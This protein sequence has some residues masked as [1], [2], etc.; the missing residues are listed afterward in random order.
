VISSVF[1]FLWPPLTAALAWYLYSRLSPD[2]PAA[3][4][5][6]SAD[7]RVGD[8][9]PLVRLRRLGGP[10]PDPRNTLTRWL[11]LAAGTLAILHFNGGH[12]MN[13]PLGPTP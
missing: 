3:L 7:P 2:V 10:G 5:A 4:A 11:T 9:D 12:P 6:T 8:R 1:G 13:T